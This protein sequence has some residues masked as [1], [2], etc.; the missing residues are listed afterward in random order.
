MTRIRFVIPVLI[1]ATTALLTHSAGAGPSP[2]PSPTPPP[3]VAALSRL[4]G[5]AFDTAFM[6][7]LIPAH[8]EA[9]EIAMA[10]TLN[11]DHPELLRWN[12]VMI[13]RKSGQV[14]Q[15]LA[16]LQQ[17]GASPGKRNANVVT[18]P[19]KRMRSLSGAALE[20]A[21]LPLIAAHLDH[22]VALAKVATA[23]ASRQELR[24][25]AQTVVAV[26][27]RE[28]A[29]LRDWLRKWYPK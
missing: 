8:E 9:I 10:A 1:A 26:E 23:R 4:N 29:M 28:A 20:R 15:M 17:V 11:A 24:A 25:L 7:E 16:W 3:T 18:D 5:P 19:V 13:D 6:R 27:G 21:Y 14:R 12:Q 2:V 22:S